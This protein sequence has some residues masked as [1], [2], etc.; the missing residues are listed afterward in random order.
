[1][2]RSPAG[3]HGTTLAGVSGFEQ[4]GLRFDL[5]R[6]GVSIDDPEVIQVDVD[7]ADLGIE[8]DDAADEIR[9]R[10]AALTG[11]PLDQDE[12]YDLVV[13]K[14]GHVVAALV[15]ACEEDVLELA[16]ERTVEVEDEELAEALLEA[17]ARASV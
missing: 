11:Q 17:L 12:L 3:C 16:G 14:S 4:R 7:W 2:S 10:L 1:M 13:S 6:E 9:R 8:P 15:V 5:D